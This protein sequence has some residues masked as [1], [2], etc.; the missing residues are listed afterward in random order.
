MSYSTTLFGKIKEEFI[1][2]S[3]CIPL[4]FEEEGEVKRERG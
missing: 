3:L 2:L 4:S 1:Y